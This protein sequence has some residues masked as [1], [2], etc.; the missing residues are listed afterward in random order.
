[1][2]FSVWYMVVYPKI[3]KLESQCGVISWDHLNRFTSEIHLLLQLDSVAECM[4]RLKLLSKALDV[5][6]LRLDGTT[7]PWRQEL[8]Q[9]QGAGLGLDIKESLLEAWGLVLLANNQ[10]DPQK[11]GELVS[12][13][14][15]LPVYCTCLDVVAMGPENGG[16]F[17]WEYW[18]FGCLA[19]QSNSRVQHKM[20]QHH[21]QVQTSAC[22]P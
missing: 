5:S 2:V 14:D 1:M 21:H 11:S 12:Q 16:C 22:S 4:S 20:S 10:L 8:V 18:S 19:R 7:G 3:R 15:P 6:N 13:K 17:C 9:L